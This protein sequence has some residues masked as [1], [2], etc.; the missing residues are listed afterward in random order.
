MNNA[1][2]ITRA[3][4]R[5]ADRRRNTRHVGPNVRT[6][7]IYVVMPDDAKAFGP[8]WLELYITAQIQEAA[9]NAAAE[10]VREVYG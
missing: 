9:T 5:A 3:A 8:T 7:T 10:I 4:V 2:K 1:V 6:L